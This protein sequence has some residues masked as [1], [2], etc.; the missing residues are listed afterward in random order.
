MIS[1]WPGDG[2]ANDIQDGNTLVQGNG[3][4]FSYAA[5]K[6][7]QAFSFDGT[8]FATA[9]TPANLQIAST[10]VTI[11]AWLRPNTSNLDGHFFGKALS[12][13]HD[14]AVLFANG[15][16]IGSDTTKAFTFTWDGPVPG[17]YTLTAVATDGQGAQTTSN[18]RTVTVEQ[19]PCT[20]RNPRVIRM[21]TFGPDIA[22]RIGLSIANV[23]RAG[24][25]VRASVAV[26]NRSGE[27][28]DQRQIFC[29]IATHAR[30]VIEER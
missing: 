2:N 17:T 18:A 23:R 9:G 1:W 26:E 13:S 10:Q 15:T 11:D 22:P 29:V 27:R 5:G 28:L 19:Q 4:G 3:N 30:A 16:L 14:Y 6:V 20:E 7:S 25:R 24:T 21:R 12:G 8:Q